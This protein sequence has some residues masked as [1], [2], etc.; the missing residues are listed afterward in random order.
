MLLG[1]SPSNRAKVVSAGSTDLI[2]LELSFTLP[3]WELVCDDEGCLLELDWPLEALLIDMS[4][5][6]SNYDNDSDNFW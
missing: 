3:D 5:E 1:G 4:V 6:L 2:L